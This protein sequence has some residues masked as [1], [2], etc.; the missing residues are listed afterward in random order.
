MSQDASVAPNTEQQQQQQKKG[1][2]M[3]VVVRLRKQPT[4]L[5]DPLG[6]PYFHSDMTGAHLQKRTGI[7][8]YSL[9][10]EKKTKVKA[11]A[12]YGA[13]ADANEASA[14]LRA[15]LNAGNVTQERHD[16]LQADLKRYVAEGSPAVEGAVLTAQEALALRL[17]QSKQPRVLHYLIFDDQKELT[18]S[19]PSEASYEAAGF[20][21]AVT[22]GSEKIGKYT[23]VLDYINQQ[24]IATET[25]M[26]DGDLDAFARA[27]KR[28]RVTLEAKQ[29]DTSV[30]I[31]CKDSFARMQLAKEARKIKAAEAGRAKAQAERA[32][33]RSDLFRPVTPAQAEQGDE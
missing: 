7:P 26:S 23:L 9:D 20:L 11:V 5:L 12:L 33:K 1:R 14:W 28:D 30:R 6:K 13:F 24:A 4:V 8:L 21:Q 22:G 10:K 16:E 27:F 3:D 29:A 18:I 31:I 19:T 15:H 17:E 32:R 2:G 25:Q